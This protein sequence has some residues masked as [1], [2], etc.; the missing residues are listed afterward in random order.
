MRRVKVGVSAPPP[1]W[2]V[3]ECDGGRLDY[4]HE[5]HLVEHSNYAR[6]IPPAESQH[7][8]QIV[9]VADHCGLALAAWL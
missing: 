3:V 7:T 5:R 4:N 2:E 1:A 6:K 8:L 9:E